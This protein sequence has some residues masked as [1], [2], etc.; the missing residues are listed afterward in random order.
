ECGADCVKIQKSCLSAKFT[1]SALARPYDSEHSFGETYGEHK[2]NL[3]FSP[4]EVK[5]LQEYATEIGLPLTASA[6]DIVPHVH[7]RVMDTYAQMFPHAHIGYSGHELG[8][9]ISVAAVARGARV[10]ERHLTLNKGWKGSD[11]ACS[12]EPHEFRQLVNAIR[13]VESALGS[14]LK[15][16][17]PSE[18]VCYRKLGKSVVTARDL[19]A[20]EEL[21]EDDLVAKVCEPPGLPAQVLY[22][23]VGRRLK[24]NISSNI[25]LSE[26]DLLT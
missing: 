9:H 17:Q 25:P 10:L 15:A 22:T 19:S 3:E 5:V 12:L 23:L 18:D 2:A 11:H 16:M 14:P 4:D 13:N 26:D 6:M 21:H 24:R 7:L 20:G 8:I 1:A